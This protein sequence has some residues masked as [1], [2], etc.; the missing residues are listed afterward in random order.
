MGTLEIRRKQRQSGGRYLPGNGNSYPTDLTVYNGALY[1]GANGN[2]GAGHELWKFDGTNVS[3]VADISPGANDGFYCS[4]SSAVV[5]N[6]VLYFCANDGNG[7]EGNELWQ[8]NG[9]VASLALDI[10]PGS[11]GSNPS[12]AAVFDGELYFQANG[13]DTAFTELRKFD[14][15]SASLAADVN[16]SGSSQ[17]FDLTV[18]DEEVVRCRRRCDRFADVE[19]CSRH[20]P[21]RGQFDPSRQCQSNQCILSGFYGDFFRGCHRR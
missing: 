16:P 4:S 12:Y 9:S 21:A 1:F 10:R 5:Y 3:R 19:I 2:D 17:P 6:G 15:A 14:G 7:N 13:D 18:Y 8:Y 11:D 20:H